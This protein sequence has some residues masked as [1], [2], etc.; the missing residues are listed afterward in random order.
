MNKDQNDDIK[1]KD[2]KD[3]ESRQ[4]RFM[5]RAALVVSG[6]IMLS[7]AATEMM[8]LVLFGR[9]EDASTKEFP[10]R[11]WAYRQEL[12]WHEV[13]Y[14]SGENLLKGYLITNQNPRALMIIAHGMNA[15]SDG[16]EPV[17]QYFAKLGYA[18]WIFDGTASGRSEGE[19]VIGLQQQRFDIRATVDYLREQ[20]LF[21]NIP[22][23]LLGHSAGA[24][25]AA[26]EAQRA[27]ADAVVCVS[28]FHAPLTTMH[29]WA[30]NYT[31]I[32]ADVQYPFLYAN[33][34]ADLG[35]QTN[36]SAAEALS[37]L[38]VPALV[39]QGANDETVE[40]KISLYYKSKEMAPAN[41]SFILETDPDHDGHD[42]ILF[43]G[44]RANYDLLDQIE[45]F[46]A[47]SIA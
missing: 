45:G 23:V 10:L 25:G 12:D 14:P 1:Q 4:K 29:H 39:I 16:F 36:E 34:H 26:T 7:V 5:R 9:K 38:N 33:Q 42:T 20:K 21:Q 43:N 28:G 19:K 2:K 41:V 13:Q 31:S 18:V 37:E 8:M 17:V 27:E 35:E 47:S 6:A 11:D 3:K 44:P 15:S 40:D 32:L 22:L 30:R 46:L 24:Y